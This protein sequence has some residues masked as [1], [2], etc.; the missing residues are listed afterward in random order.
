MVAGSFFGINSSK[1]FP[2][3][4]II[5]WTARADWNQIAAELR[6]WH[7]LRETLSN[8]RNLLKSRF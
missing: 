6:I 7:D 4:L 2:L 1:Y 8:V 5:M 3:L